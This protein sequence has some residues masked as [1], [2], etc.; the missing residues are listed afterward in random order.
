MEKAYYD[1]VIVGGG[2]SGVCAAAAFFNSNYNV[3]VIEKCDSLGGTTTNSKVCTWIE[4]CLLDFQANIFSELVDEGSLSGQLDNSW[5]PTKFSQNQGCSIDYDPDML[6]EKYI[7]Y[8][9]ECSNIKLFLNYTLSDIGEKTS[10]AVNTVIVKEELSGKKLE[11]KAK[12]FIDCTGDGL[13]CRLFADQ[14]M[15]GFNKGLNTYYFIGRD[16]KNRFKESLAMEYG[17]T[18]C[19]NEP[20]L[21][22]EVYEGDEDIELMEQINTVYAK[23]NN[24]IIP[25]GVFLSNQ[26]FDSQKYDIN[27][28]KIV[29]PEYINQDGYMFSIP[30]QNKLRYFCN[31]MN[32]IGL[33]GDFCINVGMEKTKDIAEKRSFEYWKYIKYSLLLASRKGDVGFW[34]HSGWR[35]SES[36]FSLKDIKSKLLG[37][38]ES[39]RIRCISMLTLNNLT[40]SIKEYAY[41]NEGK[42]YIAIG[43]HNVDMHNQ[44]GI[45][46]IS[47]FNSEYLR[48]YGIAYE[49]LVPDFINNT[50]VAGKAFGSSQLAQSSARIIKTV[51]QL[52]W[53][54]GM[55]IKLCLDK[56]L[57]STKL[58]ED[59]INILKSE[60]Y[61][62]FDK[63][64]KNYINKMK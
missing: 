31:S 16:P 19:L 47:Y 61:T 53:T 52:G 33:S 13:L 36:R 15:G 27:K 55:A 42:H 17:D 5:V 6:N 45:N 50:L 43:S 26:L 40:K 18:T 20:S 39:Y 3:A 23:I 25:D 41:T 48:P 4:G 49:C 11:F 62:N 37:I 29:K 34:N 24:E 44:K 64:L 63:T 7:K 60:N 35:V 57:N 12:F 56:E 46:G 51:S 38:R 30:S 28:I 2:T 10:Y 8:F 22:F 21:F 54:S 1:V 9:K 14:L 59:M 32:G 58:S